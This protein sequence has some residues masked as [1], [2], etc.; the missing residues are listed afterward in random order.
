[1][2]LFFLAAETLEETLLIGDVCADFDSAIQHM[3]NN[4]TVPQQKKQK[5]KQKCNVATEGED[6]SVSDVMV[7]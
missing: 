5:T 1:M 7:K 6:R 4:Q 3:K 2:F